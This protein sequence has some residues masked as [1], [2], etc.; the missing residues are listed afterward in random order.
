MA[1]RAPTDVSA[2]LATHLLGKKPAANDPF[3]D[4]AAWGPPEEAVR[5]LV[6]AAAV[7]KRQEAALRALD[8]RSKAWNA[9]LGVS[10][11]PVATGP[12]DAMLAA[13]TEWLGKMERWPLY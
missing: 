10:E 2:A 5:A 13:C 1:R 4:I 12:A 6:A 11:A 9:G 3:A 8:E 7:P